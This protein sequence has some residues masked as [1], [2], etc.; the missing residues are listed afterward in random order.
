MISSHTVNALDGIEV[1]V[2]ENFKPIEKVTLPMRY[3]QADPTDV[4][5]TAQVCIGLSA[6]PF[7]IHT[8]PVKD[9]GKVN[10]WGSVNFQIHLPS[11]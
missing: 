6:V 5:Q 1:K 7:K 8:P 11:V 3:R 9:F 4:L 10:H 2:G